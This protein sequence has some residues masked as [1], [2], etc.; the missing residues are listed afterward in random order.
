MRPSQGRLRQPP[1]GPVLPKPPLAFRSRWPALFAVLN[2]GLALLFPASGAAAR[3]WDIRRDPGAG[4]LAQGPSALVR[5]SQAFPGQN[6]GAQ[7][8]F[9]SVPIEPPPETIGTFTP[10]ILPP[11]TGFPIFNY[12][13]WPL[14]PAL[15]LPQAITSSSDPEGPD[16]EDRRRREEEEQQ[17]QAQPPTPV[18]TPAP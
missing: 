11:R 17:G 1:R 14:T 3:V 4:W 5:P 13:F 9:P 6:S 7:P 8:S 10:G 18:Q 12:L 2:G 16:D 15:P